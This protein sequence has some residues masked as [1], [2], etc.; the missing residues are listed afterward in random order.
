MILILVDMPKIVALDP[1]LL[2]EEHQQILNDLG[3]LVMY[4]SVPTSN[5]EIVRRLKGAE[6]VIDF[7]T[8][9]PKNVIDQLPQTKM[10]CSAA[11]GC[12]WIDVGACQRKGIA[13]THCPGHNCESVAEHTL[14]LIL[15]ALR[16]INQA[17]N[18]THHGRYHPSGYKGM[19]LQGRTLGVIGYGAIGKR[20]AEIAQHGFGMKILFTNS[21]SSRKDL[22][23]LLRVSDVISINAP[24]NEQTKNL[25]GANEFNLMKKD[26]VL[27]NTGR[28]GI[29]DEQALVQAIKSGKVFAAGLDI[30]TVEPFEKNNPLFDFPNVIITPHSA[31]NT[32]ETDYR[33]SAQVTEIVSAFI[34]GQVFYQVTE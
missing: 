13:V 31:W 7:W 11:V 23:K 24:L 9:L 29:I 14:A 12:D 8:A 30:L 21:T 25:I 27:V 20:V 17:T 22:E 10:I 28:G 33:L 4:D 2:F 18:D 19:E 3:E 26:V 34:H 5:S 6:I 32:I 1:I 16:K 15:S